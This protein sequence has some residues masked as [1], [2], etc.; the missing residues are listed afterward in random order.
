MGSLIIA[1]LQESQDDNQMDKE[2][3]HKHNTLDFYQIL[4]KEPG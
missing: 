4:M 2:S 1:H 3:L